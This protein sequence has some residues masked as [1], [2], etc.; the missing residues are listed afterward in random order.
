MSIVKGMINQSTIPNE[1]EATMQYNAKRMTATVITQFFTYIVSYGLPYSYIPTGEAFVS[2]WLCAEKP[3]TIY[4]RWVEPGLEIAATTTAAALTEAGSLLLGL[5]H[6]NVS[7]DVLE[8][9]PIPEDS[10]EV[11]TTER[12]KR[13][14]SHATIR[15]IRGL[16]RSTLEMNKAAYKKAIDRGG[17][18]EQQHQYH[19]VAVLTCDGFHHS[20]VSLKQEEP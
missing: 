17:E 11:S 4:H 9:A 7:A 20:N 3:S 10:L 14:L 16:T 2:L 13:G 5:I 15:L 8:E 12:L 18:E 1:P 6:S 19:M